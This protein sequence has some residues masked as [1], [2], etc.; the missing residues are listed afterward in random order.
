MIKNLEVLNGTDYEVTVDR[1]EEG[2]YYVEVRKPAHT[3]DP[4]I[5][6]EVVATR[7]LSG[8]STENTLENTVATIIANDRPSLVG[9][10]ASKEV[11]T[12]GN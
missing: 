12:N 10:Y 1:D 11:V 6:Y 3:D 5:E 4:Y 8:D 2:D 7:F 9:K